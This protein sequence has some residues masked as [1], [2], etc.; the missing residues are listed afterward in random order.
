MTARSHQTVVLAKIPIIKV[1]FSFIKQ[2]EPIRK[3]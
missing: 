1:R 3:F 2:I